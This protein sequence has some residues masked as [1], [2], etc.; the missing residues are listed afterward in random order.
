MSLRQSPDTVPGTQEMLHKG[1][2]ESR[3]HVRLFETPWTVYSTEFSR[4][5]YWSG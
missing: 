2:S 5:E 3:C 1:E 4:S